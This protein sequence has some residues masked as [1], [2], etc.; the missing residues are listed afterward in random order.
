MDTDN[1][2]NLD[3]V[4]QLPS[5]LGSSGVYEQGDT[6]ANSF[7]ILYCMAAARTPVPLSLCWAMDYLTGSDGWPRRSADTSKWHGR[8]G[9][10]SRDQLTPYLCYLIASRGSK[11]EFSSV[12]LAM[13]KHGFLFAN[14]YRR[15]FVYEDEQEHLLKST[16]DVRWRPG[17]KL[18]DL[19]GPDIWAVCLRGLVMRGPR[20]LKGVA[21]PAL[22]LL[23]V[24]GLVSAVASKLKGRPQIS[25]E[26]N[27]ALKTHFAANYLPTFVSKLTYKV[28][29][30]TK[31]QIAFKAFWEQRGEPRVDLWMSKLFP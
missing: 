27:F 21:Y 4:W 5:Y 31:P 11:D 23:D 15:N 25:D 2:L 7:S 8:V 14:N 16:V 18:P 6:C 9:R 26:R 28:Y 20:I 3:P 22:C 24:Q 10:C 13:A 12:L 30:S 17:W 1:L 19:L 29:A